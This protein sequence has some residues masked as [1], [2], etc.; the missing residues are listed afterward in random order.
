MTPTHGL[1]PTLTRLVTTTNAHDLDGL[2][3]CFAED[4][5]LTMPNHP[6]RNFTGPGQVR[7]N[8]DQFFTLMPDIQTTITDACRGEGDEWW[9]E[10][11]ISGTRRDGSRHL[12]RGVMI[13]TV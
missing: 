2:V 3:S 11:E 7:R 13:M 10:W 8:W 1:P 4:Y 12:M 9:T 6:A 5:R